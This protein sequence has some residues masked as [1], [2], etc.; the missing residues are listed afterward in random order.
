MKQIVSITLIIGGSMLLFGCSRSNDAEL[1][2]LCTE[3]EAARAEVVEARAEA[4]AANAALPKRPQPGTGLRIWRDAE[5]EEFCKWVGIEADCFKFEGGWID[6]WIEIDVGGERHR[7]ESAAPLHRISARDNVQKDPVV[8][9]P[10]GSFLWIRRV[11]KQELCVLPFRFSV[12][13]ANGMASGSSNPRLAD[14][15][16]QPSV[17]GNERLI[18]GDAEVLLNGDDVVTLVTLMNEGET[19]GEITRTAK[20]HCKALK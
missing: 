17:K 5:A 14:G 1:A 10:S 3:A 19:K 4:E 16:P 6:C 11:D 7:L 18:R 9:Q 20:L 8:G 13:T 2:K 12:K 15:P